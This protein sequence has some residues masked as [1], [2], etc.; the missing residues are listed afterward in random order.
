MTINVIDSNTVDI[1]TKQ[2][3]KV[4]EHESDMVS[5]DGKTLVDKFTD[6]SGTQPVDGEMTYTRVSAGPAG[7]H[8]ISGSWMAN[9]VNNVSQNGLTVTYQVTGRRNE[10]VGPHRGEFRRQIRRKVRIPFNGDPG[11]SMIS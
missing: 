4:V 6:H 2:G 7:S 10:D 8:A 1:T 11:H 5:A 3:G 9:K